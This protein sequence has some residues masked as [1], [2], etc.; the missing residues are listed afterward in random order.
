MAGRATG[1]GVCAVLYGLVKYPY[2]MGSYGMSFMEATGIIAFSIL[3]AFAAV[4]IIHD[5]RDI[6]V[7]AIVHVFMDLIQNV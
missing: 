7:M 2:Y 3:V 4:S 6:L 5:R 1:I